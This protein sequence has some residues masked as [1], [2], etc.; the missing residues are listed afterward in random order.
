MKIVIE[1]N[2]TQVMFALESNENISVNVGG[3]VV[4]ISIHEFRKMRNF[5]ENEI[6]EREELRRIENSW[7]RRLLKIR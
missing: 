6:E 1:N 2:D 3:N 4:E 7:Y 5:I